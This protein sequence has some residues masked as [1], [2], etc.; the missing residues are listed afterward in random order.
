MESK[1]LPAPLNW[2]VRPPDEAHAASLASSLGI[3]PV[4]AQLLIVRG[5][6]EPAEA[7]RFLNP[8]L[9]HLHDPFKL[10]DLPKAVERLLR[11]V[12]K[13]ERI[14][15]HGDYDVDGVTSTVILRRLLELLGAD[16]VHFIP[17]RLKDGYGG[18]GGLRYPEQRGRRQ[19][20]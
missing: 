18:L 20:P 14:A 8:S 13:R 1:P 11:A 4:I 2:D 3:D 19:S 7:T 10:V 9:D 5:I 12:D 17:D 15:V 6:T 16:V